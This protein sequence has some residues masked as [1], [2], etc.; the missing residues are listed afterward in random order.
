[1]RDARHHAAARELSTAIRKLNPKVADEF[2]GLLAGDEAGAVSFLRRSVPT[3]AISELDG[4]SGDT[5]LD[6]NATLSAGRPAVSR[7]VETQLGVKLARFRVGLELSEELARAAWIAT[8]A[9]PLD[10]PALRRL[11]AVALAHWA[12]TI[13]DDERMFMAALM[14]ADNARRL[15]AEHPYGMFQ[16][17]EIS[18]AASSITAA[19][20]RFVEDVGRQD[21]PEDRTD[22]KA[23]HVEGDTRE[24]DRQIREMAGRFSSVADAALKLADQI[25]V[26]HAGVYFAMLGG[27]SDSTPDD[28][29]FAGFAY[30]VGLQAGLDVARDI[31]PGRLRVDAVPRGYLAQIDADAE[32]AYYARGGTAKGD[33]L[34]LPWDTDPERLD[35][36]ATIVHELKHAATDKEQANVTNAQDELRSFEAEMRY[37]VAQIQPLT[38]AARTKAVGDAAKG[39]GEVEILAAIGA[40]RDDADPPDPDAVKVVEELNAAV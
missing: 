36:R 23:P 39:G 4:L 26:I 13:D 34:Y 33:T 38:G 2:D 31:P 27:A 25:G 12:S 32:G 5:S 11:R 24:L 8:A 35:D 37:V 1:V 6:R 19:N 16:D 14:D 18:Y 28:R 29:A 20:R 10:E 7:R 17:A 30:V 15:H 3:G 9:G 21:R 22:P 40:I